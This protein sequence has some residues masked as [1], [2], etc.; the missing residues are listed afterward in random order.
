MVGGRGSHAGE[1]CLQQRDVTAGSPAASRGER[2]T[3]WTLCR[4]P[5]QVPRNDGQAEKTDLQLLYP[6]AVG[7]E[8]D[9]VH[10][11]M[12]PDRA[13]EGVARHDQEVRGVGLGGGGGKGG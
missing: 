9:D 11:V 2:H 4:D 8:S 10:L 6:L 3:T 7:T 13:G 1:V 5:L 12:F